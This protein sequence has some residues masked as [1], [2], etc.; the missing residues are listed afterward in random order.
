MLE[1]EDPVVKWFS[2]T[3]LRPFLAALE[4]PARGHYLAEY[5]ARMRDAY[6]PQPDGRTL[7]TMRRIFVLAVR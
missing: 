1:G 2:A 3:A 7:F 5:T 6:P 4:E